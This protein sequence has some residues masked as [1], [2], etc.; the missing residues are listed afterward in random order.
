ML[1]DLGHARGAAGLDDACGHPVV[2]PAAQ[3][4]AAQQLAPDRQ[5]ELA[6]RRCLATDLL[7]RQRAGG[8]RRVAQRP[9]LAAAHVDEPGMDR[10]EPRRRDAGDP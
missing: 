9:L 8:G 7:R 4:V 3:R 2:E 5:R 1:E 10:G 6:H